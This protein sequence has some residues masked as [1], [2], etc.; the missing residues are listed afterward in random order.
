LGHGCRVRGRGE[1]AGALFGGLTPSGVQRR[2]A[3]IGRR[4]GVEVHPHALRHTFAR[5]LVDGGI[6]LHEALEH[7]VGALKEG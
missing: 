3:E 6:G 2:L 1:G 5:N 7:A 4:A